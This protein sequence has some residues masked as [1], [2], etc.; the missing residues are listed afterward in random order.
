MQDVE[1]SPRSAGRLQRRPGQ[2]A[3]RMPKKR[4]R[5]GVCPADVPASV[6]ADVPGECHHAIG[7]HFWRRRLPEG[8]FRFLEVVVEGLSLLV[9]GR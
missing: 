5:S 9:E 2:A 6:D 8:R 4:R 7:H 3:A 1:G